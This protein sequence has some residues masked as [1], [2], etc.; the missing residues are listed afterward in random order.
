MRE[1]CGRS[2]LAAQNVLCAKSDIRVHKKLNDAAFYRHDEIDFR[3]IYA[4]AVE[5]LE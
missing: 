3:S 2:T 4:L 1:R 5:N